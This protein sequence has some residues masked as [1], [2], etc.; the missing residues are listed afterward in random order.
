[1]YKLITKYIYIYIYI[2]IIYSYLFDLST[3][4]INPLISDSLLC[5]KLIINHFMRYIL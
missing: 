3:I 1:M 2:Y 5:S 4:Y